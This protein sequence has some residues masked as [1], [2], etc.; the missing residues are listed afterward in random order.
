MGKRRKKK[1]KSDLKYEPPDEKMGKPITVV[2]QTNRGKAEPPENQLSDSELT[3]RVNKAINSGRIAQDDPLVLK[4]MR[5]ERKMQQIRLE[6]EQEELRIAQ[7]LETRR[8][9]IATRYCYPNESFEKVPLEETHTLK[10][11]TKAVVNV[12][13]LCY[14]QINEMDQLE[15]FQKSEDLTRSDSVCSSKDFG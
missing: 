14:A 11:E 9:L 7:L 3:I 13:S 2:N 12:I 1:I 5:L 10:Q 15:E 6:K 4:M 8:R